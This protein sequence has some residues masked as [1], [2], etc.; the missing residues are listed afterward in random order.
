MKAPPFAYVRAESLAEVFE[1]LESHGDDARLLAGGQSLLAALNLRLSSPALLIDITRIDGLS[2]ITVTHGNVS[3]GALTTH[4]EIE[5]SREIAAC[6]PLLAAAAPHIAHPAIRN[7]GTFGGSIAMADPAT[8]W[9]ACCIALDARF[10]LASRSGTR[11]VRARDFFQGLYT[12]ALKPGEVLTTI[13]VPTAGDDYRSA[14]VELTRRRGDYAIV[15]IA[16]LARNSGGTLSDVRLAYLGVGSTP[17]LA[18]AAQAAVEGQTLSAEVIAAAVQ[19]VA[20]D[21]DPDGD[22]ELSPATRLHL[23][24]VITGRALTALAA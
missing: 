7:V 19:A 14:F 12:T 1:L 23:A 5:R 24:R 2:G 4:A 17:M 22:S 15:G 3:I 11:R 18:P 20:T 16:A 9:P 8:E 21:L 13:E 6:L 10:V